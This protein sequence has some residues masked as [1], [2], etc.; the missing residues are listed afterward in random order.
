MFEKGQV[1]NYEIIDN[2]DD[3]FFLELE[4]KGKVYQSQMFKR[5]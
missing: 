5:K 4:W 2:Q 1:F 3:F